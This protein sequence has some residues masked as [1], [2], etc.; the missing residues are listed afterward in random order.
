MTGS[1]EDN[2]LEWRGTVP[3]AARFGDVYYSVDDPQGEVR[4]T[5]LG[6]TGFTDLCHKD[7]LCVAETGFGTGLNF[8]EAWETWSRNAGPDAYLTFLS[9]EAFPLSRGDLRRAH[10]AF[11]DHRQRSEELIAAWP[12]AIPGIHRIRLAQGRIRLILLIGDAAAMLAALSFQADAWFLD[13]FAP[14]R[15]PDM[16][17]PEVLAQV[18][19]NSA[20]G[21]RLASFT[22][23]GEVRRGLSAQGFVVEKRPGFG[24]KR[25]CITATFN[26]SGASNDLPW[27]VPPA[28]LPKDSRIAIVGDGIAGRA[29]ARALRD[30]HRSTIRIAGDRSRAYAA[31][32][33]PRALIAPKLIRGDQPFATFWRQAYWD[34]VRELETLDGGDVWVGPRGLRIDADDAAGL[35]KL[36]KLESDLNWPPDCLRSIGR[37][38]AIPGGLFVSQAGSVDPAALLARLG[39]APEI[40]SD[41]G[42]VRRDGDTWHL[43]D[44]NGRL[45]L[46]ADA[47][48][49]ACGPGASALLPGVPGGFGMRIGAGQC[50]VLRGQSGPDHAVLNNGYWTAADANG[51]FVLGATATPRAPL[52]PVPVSASATEELLHRQGTLLAD[53]RAQVEAAWTGLRCDTGDHLPLAG[54]V[55]DPESFARDYADLADGKPSGGMPDATYQPGLFTLSALGARGFQGAFLAADLIAALIDGGPAP[56]S[57]AVRHALA[58]SRFQIRAITRNRSSSA[59]R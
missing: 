50:L 20:P 7:R 15:N 44:H 36:Q 27:H 2:R 4:H 53:H 45:L 32:T 6:G 49:L 52:A 47:V 39:D 22:A 24:R 12:G 14:S 55:Q 43:L 11:P 54:P 13:G 31:S 48:I 33:L 28:P 10:D 57:D 46:Q 8:L 23:A 37:D 29:V 18:A 26:G 19:R 40:D 30:R 16:W 25:D 51:R 3:Y 1:S 58:P 59:Q 35:E 41:V 5:F 21:A 42:E 9:V 34:A 56:V 17:R 38:N